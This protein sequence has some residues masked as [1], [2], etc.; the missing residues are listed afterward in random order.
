MAADTPNTEPTRPINRT[1]ASL[2][3]VPHWIE[4]EVRAYH[5]MREDPPIEKNLPDLL[6]KLA[7]DTHDS[8]FR[9][10]ESFHKWKRRD[11]KSR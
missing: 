11:W 3:I 6:G 1:L 7:K 9:R 2:G 4:S 8:I 10:A 5:E